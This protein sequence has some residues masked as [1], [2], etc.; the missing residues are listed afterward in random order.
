MLDDVLMEV[1][2]PSGSIKTGSVT[3]HWAPTGIS[4]ITQKTFD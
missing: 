1:F 4:Q 3:P 2:N